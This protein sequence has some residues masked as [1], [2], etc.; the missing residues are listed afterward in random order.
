[1]SV[2]FIPSVFRIFSSKLLVFFKLEHL[3]EEFS[4][5][6]KTTFRSFGLYVIGSIISGLSYFYVVLA[7]WPSLTVADLFFIIAAVN[8]AGVAGTITPLLPSGIGV[9]D[10]TL[11]VLLSQI[12]PIEVALAVTVFSRLWSILI[13]ILFFLITRIEFLP[14][15]KILR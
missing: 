4:I 15:D 1:M 13:D 9:R 2:L 3:S 14:R 7:V 8:L 10:T 6:G 11:L 5:N 12:M